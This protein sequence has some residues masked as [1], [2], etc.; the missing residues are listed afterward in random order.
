MYINKREICG[1]TGLTAETVLLSMK[2]RIWA[3]KEKMAMT[4]RMMD[5]AGL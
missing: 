4:L 2:L 1:D 3:A 5:K